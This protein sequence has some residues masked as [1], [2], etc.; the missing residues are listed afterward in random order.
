MK[1]KVLLV[2]FGLFFPTYQGCADFTE[3]APNALVEQARGAGPGRVAAAGG[4]REAVPS[5]DEDAVFRLDGE[6]TKVAFVGS[7]MVGSHDGG[8]ARM[9]G[10]LVVPSSDPRGAR[11]RLEVVTSSVYTDNEQL[12]AHLK[13]PDF[14]DVEKHPVATFES[15]AVAADRS[16]DG[17]H[18]I[19]GDLTFMGITRSISFP[20]RARLEGT[21]AR[22][23]A[24]FVINRKDFGVVYPGMPDNLIKDEVLIKISL[25]AA[26]R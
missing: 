5:G 4:E 1:R 18:T 23:A 6:N 25:D 21:S 19:T 22:V 26:S 8:F 3:G 24:E 10:E 17:T 9:T 16:K 13:S 15:R 12:T 20:A 2:A 14:F 7:K 11:I